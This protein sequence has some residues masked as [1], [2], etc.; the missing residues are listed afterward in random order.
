VAL[1]ST[2]FFANGGNLNEFAGNMPH[3]I[4]CSFIVLDSM[5]EFGKAITRRWVI[6]LA[7]F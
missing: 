5:F 6:G 7:S 2:A 1:S 3:F 4:E